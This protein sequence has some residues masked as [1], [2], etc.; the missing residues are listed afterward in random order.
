LFS[1]DGITEAVNE[2][3]QEYGLK[4]LA[5]HATGSAASAV[6]IVDD[7]RTFANGTA[8]RD[9]ATVVFVGVGR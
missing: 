3:E 6:S 7:V 4:R 8:V 9:D 5:E 2:E 1:S